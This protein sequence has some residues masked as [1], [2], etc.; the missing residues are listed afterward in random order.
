MQTVTTRNAISPCSG[1]CRALYQCMHTVRQDCVWSFQYP[2]IAFGCHVE[3]PNTIKTGTANWCCQNRKML[4]MRPDCRSVYPVHNCSVPA[5][6]LSSAGVQS[7]KG[8]MAIVLVSMCGS[9]ACCRQMALGLWESYANIFRFLPLRVSAV[10]WRKN[11]SSLMFYCDIRSPWSPCTMRAG[12]DWKL[13]S[14]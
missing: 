5:C 9:W 7:W 14:S 4:A 6:K 8:L 10:A 12:L 2:A 3:G 1:K 11:G 13:F